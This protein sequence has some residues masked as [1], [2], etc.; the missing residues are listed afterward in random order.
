ML[1]AQARPNRRSVRGA[2]R[3]LRVGTSTRDGRG[4]GRPPTT[5][6]RRRGHR[7]SAEGLMDSGQRI[8]F[9]RSFETGSQAC[10]PS[11][12]SRRQVAPATRPKVL[13]SLAMSQGRHPGVRAREDRRRGRRVSARRNTKARPRIGPPRRR[14][15]RPRRLGSGLR[16]VQT[17]AAGTSDAARAAPAGMRL[18]RSALGLGLGRRRDPER[19]RGA[20]VRTGQAKHQHRQDFHP[21]QAPSRNRVRRRCEHLHHRRR[22]ELPEESTMLSAPPRFVKQQLVCNSP[23]RPTQRSRG[24]RDLRFS[25]VTGTKIAA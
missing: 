17:T 13:P 2:S 4:S 6:R 20:P 11:H 9:R 10:G 12:R 3:S 21:A 1:G 14:R 16:S 5:G 22:R 24:P 18:V 19:T 25:V 23:I 7:V 8:P 15:R